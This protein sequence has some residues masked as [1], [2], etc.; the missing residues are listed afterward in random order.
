VWCLMYPIILHMEGKRCVVAG[1]GRVAY[2]KITA[3]LQAKANITVISPD[4]IPEIERLYSEGNIQL[5]RKEIEYADY[6]DAFLIIAATNCPEVNRDIY[7]RVKDT[8]LVNVVSDSELGNFHIPATLSRGRLQIS[9]ATGGASPMLAKAIRDE[10]GDI[11]DESYEEFAEF[12]YQVRRIIKQSECSDEKKRE[13]Y[14]EA[15]LDKYRHS[16]EERKLF[17]KKVFTLNPSA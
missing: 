13:L 11:Y 15:L 6:Q 1:G 12:L 9:V 14:K 16:I 8:K 7:E 3:L 4:V 17:I 10:L 5:H 2:S